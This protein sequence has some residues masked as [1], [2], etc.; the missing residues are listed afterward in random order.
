MPSVPPD[1]IAM[2]AARTTLT[3]CTICAPGSR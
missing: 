2:T 3:N 1:L